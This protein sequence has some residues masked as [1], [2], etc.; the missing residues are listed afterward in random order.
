MH[1]T[2]QAWLSLPGPLDIPLDLQPCFRGH[3]EWPVLWSV[4]PGPRSDPNGAV[5]CL[6]LYTQSLQLLHHLGNSLLF[7]LGQ[8]FFLFQFG[9]LSFQAGDVTLHHSSTASQVHRS[10]PRPTTNWN[11]LSGS[12]QSSLKDQCSCPEWFPFVICIIRTDSLFTHFVSI[13]FNLFN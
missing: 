1:D 5:V 12:L 7:L 11:A 9:Y 8:N 4:Y 3:P 2:S 13:N 6:E 10:W